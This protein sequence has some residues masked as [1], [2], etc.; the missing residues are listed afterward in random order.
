MKS[1][2]INQFFGRY[3]AFLLRWRWVVIALFAILLFVAFKGMPYVTQQKTVYIGQEMGRLVMI[4][5]IIC[6]LVMLLMTRSLRG[7]VCPLL[8]VLGGVDFSLMALL[9]NALTLS[10]FAY[11][12]VRD[13]G[14]FNR[15]S[16][17]WAATDQ[18]HAILGYDYFYAKAGLFTT[19]TRNSEVWLK[20]KYSW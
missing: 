7:I 8:S 19:Y 16:A 15:L 5:A 13:L 3:A 2:R 10:T 6:I 20:V 9:N 14:V 18:L 11:A 1:H 4:A 12:D 17:D